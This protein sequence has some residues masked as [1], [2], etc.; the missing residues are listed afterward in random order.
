MSEQ[1]T[2][3]VTN[4]GKM[5]LNVGAYTVP[6]GET[7]ILISPRLDPPSTRLLLHTSLQLL[8]SMTVLAHKLREII[9]RLITTW[10]RS[11]LLMRPE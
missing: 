7:R 2:I 3:P 9:T 11:V 5:V 10:A 8:L 4:N 1:K 6:P